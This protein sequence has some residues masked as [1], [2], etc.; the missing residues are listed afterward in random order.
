[1]PLHTLKGNSATLG[2]EQIASLAAHIEHCIKTDD[3]N[4][5]AHDFRLLEVNFQQF[6]KHYRAFLNLPHNEAGSATD[7]LHER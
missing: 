2:L 1:V 3:Y 6:K 7:S 4:N 5:V